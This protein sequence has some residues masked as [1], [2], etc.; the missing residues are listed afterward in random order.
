MHKGHQRMGEPGGKFRWMMFLWGV[1]LLC[2]LV[3][4]LIILGL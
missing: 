1:G 4:N 2:L 3:G